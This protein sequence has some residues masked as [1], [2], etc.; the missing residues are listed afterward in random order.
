MKGS[1]LELEFLSC[2]RAR[3]TAKSEFFG[4]I[5]TDCVSVVEST[6]KIGGGKCMMEWCEIADGKTVCKL[7]GKFWVTREELR[8]FEK[9]LEM[10]S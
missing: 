10:G 1:D 8:A 2:E 3:E 7:E 5:G 9:Y 4:D 6:R